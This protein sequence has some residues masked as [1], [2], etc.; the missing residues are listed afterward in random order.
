PGHAK[1][2]PEVA[3]AAERAAERVGRF[4][5]DEGDAGKHL[6]FVGVPGPQTSQWYGDGYSGVGAAAS[7][8]IPDGQHRDRGAPCTSS[9]TLLRADAL[10]KLDLDFTL[11]WHLAL[12]AACVG[13]PEHDRGNWWLLEG[14][15]EYAAQGDRD[16]TTV[17]RKSDLRAVLSSWSGELTE[18]YPLNARNSDQEWRHQQTAYAAVSRLVERYGEREFIAFFNA[19][20]RKGT[21]YE[22]AAAQHLGASLSQVQSDLNAYLRSLAG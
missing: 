5:A 2:L 1:Q 4:A 6:V 3:A 13:V 21:D 17:V 10:A 8:P 9:E 11:T 19:V 20:G 15:R 18:L 14:I 16:P 7:R 12:G 22:K